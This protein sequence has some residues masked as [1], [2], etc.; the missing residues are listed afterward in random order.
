MTEKIRVKLKDN[1]LLGISSSNEAFVASKITP[2]W[3]DADQLF[4][5][6]KTA[7]KKEEFY[8]I[9]D[10]FFS[11]G[12]IEKD[13]EKKASVNEASFSLNGNEDVRDYGNLTFDKW[14]LEDAPEIPLNL[15]KEILFLYYYGK[16]LDLY[17]VIGLH[18]GTDSTEKEVEYACGQYR[19]MFATRNFIGVELGSYAKK[20]ERV[21]EILRKSFKLEESEVRENYNII[22]KGGKKGIVETEK[23]VKEKKS[24]SENPLDVA[25]KHFLNAMKY[26]SEKNIEQAYSD[27]Q[28]AL[29]IAPTNREFL[30]LKGEIDE[31]VKVQKVNVLMNAIENDDSLIMDESK[32]EKAI[33]RVLQLTDGSPLMMIK[34]A[35]SALEKEM[36]EMV[37]EYATKA[38]KIDKDL[39]S[40]ASDL[41]RK[42]ERL[43]KDFSVSNEK[44]KVFHIK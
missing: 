8:S 42:A 37:I 44:E 4:Q 13:V 31:A 18:K 39:Q 1:N 33:T 36:P 25:F 17:K 12:G 9:I 14:E 30:N 27:I 2:Q 19:R 35:Q 26:M 41:I 11:R 24:D 5:N 16:T 3:Q 6:V 40:T 20:L 29:H 10:A 21:R 38:A 34:I 32:L 15:K 23:T 22:L 43:K 28:I 7:I